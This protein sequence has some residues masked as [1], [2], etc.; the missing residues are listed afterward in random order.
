MTTFKIGR[1]VEV[2][3][4]FENTRSGFRHLAT[5]I[6]DGSEAETTKACY[7]NRTWES[8][9]YQ[10]VLQSLCEKT[11][12]N[13]SLSKYHQAKFKRLIKNNWQKEASEKIDKEFG[14]IAMVAKVA[15]IFG[16]TQKESNDRK[17][18]MIKAGLGNKGLIMPEDWDSLDE[19]TKQERLDKV[20]NELRR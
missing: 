15:G 5:L 8:Y 19:D 9:E 10:S 13:G 6:V 16:S 11:A 7:Q 18:R 4:E 12:K 1:N 2:V 14:T 20:I 3:C 17:T